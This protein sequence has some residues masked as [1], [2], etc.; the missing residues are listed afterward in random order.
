MW[1]WA[2]W[3]MEIDPECDGDGRGRKPHSLADAAIPVNSHILFSLPGSERVSFP[4]LAREGV[5]HGNRIRSE[6]TRCCLAGIVYLQTFW[7]LEQLTGF[8]V[9]DWS[10]GWVAVPADSTHN[11]HIYWKV[12]CYFDSVTK[13]RQ[14]CLIILLFIWNPGTLRVVRGIF[15][16]RK[17]QFSFPTLL[18]TRLPITLGSLCCVYRCFAIVKLVIT[19]RSWWCT[20]LHIFN[21]WHQPFLCAGWKPV[22]LQVIPPLGTGQRVMG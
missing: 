20:P 7:Q 8:S 4:S 6:V 13:W 1:I 19:S 14:A 3:V 15:N 5:W 2:Q 9:M 18:E 12:L 17:L 21:C 22:G 10:H 16:D 11:Y